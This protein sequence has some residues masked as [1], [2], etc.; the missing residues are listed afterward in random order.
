MRRIAL[1]LVVILFCV[2]P[3]YADFNWDRV[4]GDPCTLS[5]TQA[6]S[7]LSIPSFVRNEV[8]KAYQNGNYKLI[9]VSAG[10]TY[11]EM[12][13]GKGIVRQEVK[14]LWRYTPGPFQAT[15]VTINYDG[16]KYVIDR[17]VRC[18]NFCWKREPIQ[19]TNAIWVELEKPPLL[20]IKYIPPTQVMSQ[21]GM[22][23]PT[24]TTTQV[25][26]FNVMQTPVY[27]VQATANGGTQSQCQS[28]EQLQ[29]QQQE[30]QQ[31]Q[32]QNQ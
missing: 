13:F 23:V 14:C 1:V 27:Q 25:N 6:I 32:Q 19:Y 5:R 15:R 17:F 29:Q 2:S 28:Q 9:N 3:V 8:I 26:M 24:L 20:E 10:A 4:G 21:L 31:Q 22:G 16:Y 11:H 18:S 12:I 30:Q 7:L